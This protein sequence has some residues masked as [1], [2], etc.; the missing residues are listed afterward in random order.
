[1][2]NSDDSA[3]TVTTASAASAA[4]R[5]R[6]RRRGR[7]ALGHRFF[8]LSSRLAARTY[9]EGGGGASGGRRAAAVFLTFCHSS[10]NRRPTRRRRHRPRTERPWPSRARGRRRA[11]PGV[12]HVL[13]A[14]QSAAGAGGAA[15]PLRA[16]AAGPSPEHRI[17]WPQLTE[18][19]LQ[20][21]ASSAAAALS[22]CLRQ[23]LH[24]KLMQAWLAPALVIKLHRHQVGAAR[25]LDVRNPSRLSCDLETGGGS[26]VRGSRWYDDGYTGGASV[27]V[28]V[29]QQLLP[30]LHARRSGS[31][32]AALSAQVQK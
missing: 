27:A 16:A 2:T 15:P 30:H 25:V 6:R 12:G 17:L 26:G 24:H 20:P 9:A 29:A 4:A 10:S 11:R 18:N 22:Y 21:I 13:R 14:L 8:A 31:A 28:T 7:Q 32:L 23:K 5:R 3:A 1:M 19:A